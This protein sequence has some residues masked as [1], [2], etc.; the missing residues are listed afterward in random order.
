V[1]ISHKYKFIFI[2]IQKTA[3]TSISSVLDPF[4][5]DSYPSLKHWSAARIMEKF[6]SEIWENYFKFTFIRNP[7]E[8]LLS[9]YNMIDKTR[10]N[11]NPNPFHE[12]IHKNT[13]SFSDFI[14]MKDGFLSRKG[15]PPQRISQFQILSVDDRIAVDFVGR[16]ENLVGD[17]NYVCAKLNIG[18]KVLPHLNK[19]DR[20]D[21]VD[22]YTDEMIREVNLFARED[23]LYFYQ[24][25]KLS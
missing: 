1:L 9:W 6:G 17:F 10:C 24:E 12:H 13:R 23:F 5:E 25:N 15:V 19:Y 22:C 3:G 2:H 20:D 16:Y 8:R 4:C 11:P 7:Y 21:W 14:A 18:E